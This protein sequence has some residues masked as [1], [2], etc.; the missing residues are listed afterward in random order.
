MHWDVRGS[1]VENTGGGRG[2]V[3]VSLLMEERVVLEILVEEEVAMS[4]LVKEGV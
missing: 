3:G 1:S 2:S 4:V